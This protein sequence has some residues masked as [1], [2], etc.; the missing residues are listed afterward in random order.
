MNMAGLEGGQQRKIKTQA[1]FLAAL[2]VHY[3]IERTAT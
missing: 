2:D 1:G 3:L